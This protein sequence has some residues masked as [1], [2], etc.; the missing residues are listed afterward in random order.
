MTPF[1]YSESTLPLTD[2]KGERIFVQNYFFFFFE[3][4]IN[5]EQCRSSNVEQVLCTALDK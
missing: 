3:K 5:N 4:A 2:N 1:M